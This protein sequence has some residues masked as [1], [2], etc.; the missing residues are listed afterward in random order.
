[1]CISRSS[2]RFDERDTTCEHVA[3]Y[4]RKKGATA[5]GAV[6]PRLAVAEEQTRHTVHLQ[7]PFSSQRQLT[8]SKAVSRANLW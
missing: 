1:M 5:R 4:S 2:Y 8:V 6:T 7:R 3:R